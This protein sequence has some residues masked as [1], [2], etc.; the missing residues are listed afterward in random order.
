MS[1]DLPQTTPP[2]RK[3]GSFEPATAEFEVWID[4]ADAFSQESL[5]ELSKLELIKL[6][7]VLREVVTQQEAK[8]AVITE[9]GS[10]LGT[11]L[12]LDEL[13]AVVMDKV[14]GLME[15]ER[16]TLFLVDEQHDEL[17]SKVTQ[18]IV[19]TE[20]RLKV[21]QGI[22]GWVAQTGKSINIRDAYSD[23]RFNPE[24]DAKTGYETRTILC[25]PI[26]NNEGKTLGVIQVLN[27]QGG[28]FTTEDENLLSALS[29]QIAIA[30]ENSKLYLSVVEK[31]LELTELTNKLE[32]RVAE[33]DLLA[34]IDHELAHTVDLDSFI[35][36]STQKMAEVFKAQAAVLTL[37]ESDYLRGYFHVLHAEPQFYVRNIGLD[38]GISGQVVESGEP[39]LC[40]TGACDAVPGA[41]TEPLGIAVHNVMAV[42]LFD[43]EDRGIGA[44]KIVNHH[45]LDRGFTRD[46]LKV[47]ALIASRI[48][49][50][51]VTRRHH[52]E[53]EKANRLATIG[54]ML[55]G[56]VHDLKNPIAIINGY[57][58]LM[59]RSNDREKREE[60]AATIKRQFGALNQMT[61]EL[62]NFARGETSVLRRKVF[63]PNFF[64]EQ[65]ELLQK[66]LAPRDVDL[67]LDL[68]YRE[69]VH[70]DTGKFQ[71]LI[72]NLAR[73]ACDSMPDGGT[74][75]IHSH[76]ETES[77]GREMVVF[78]FEDTGTGIPL[79]IR[80]RLFEEFVTQG[81]E[82]GTGLGLA[83]VKKIVEEHEGTI[84]FVSALNEGTTFTIRIPRKPPKS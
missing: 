41:I 70:L 69:E 46:E 5:R 28:Y 13:L 48:A 63:V 76:L 73:N 66:E 52:E 23:P 36:S 64:E 32:H 10:A 55:S 9:I 81:K 80:D 79:E 11:A 4:H 75:T 53:M 34:E 3:T 62:L 71:R 47:L 8:I 51:L 65:S 50:A 16:S 27:R 6:V 67:V 17:W 42:P 78:E 83:I 38:E 21:G 68:K 29:S 26:R 59:A 74:F 84:S 33:L 1:E 82:H 2:A 44:I 31:N 20:I 54:Q 30:I 45:D 18:G 7:K 15:A 49:G 14:T 43:E 22:A 61:K 56:V 37:K 40:N 35:E 24:V 58:Q 12:Q 77:D 19:N 60:H 25:Q 57:V 72:L 39:Y